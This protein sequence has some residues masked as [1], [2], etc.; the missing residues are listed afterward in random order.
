METLLDKALKAPMKKGPERR[1][2]K[3]LYDRDQI[4][5]LS[6]AWLLGDI[7]SAQVSYALGYDRGSQFRHWIAN[8]VKDAFDQGRINII[9]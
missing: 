5:D 4:I 7:G 9:N 3:Q 6:L 2:K 8:G 1:R